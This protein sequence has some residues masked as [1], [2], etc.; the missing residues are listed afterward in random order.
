MVLTGYRYTTTLLYA[1][2]HSKDR[3][4]RDL[5]EVLVEWSPCRSTYCRS[6]WS[7]DIVNKNGDRP[8][9]VLIRLIYRCEL[10]DITAL[11]VTSSVLL[12]TVRPR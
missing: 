10:V 1:I 2:I 12:Y 8:I 6:F 9:G 5:C 11:V 4:L 7:K 3:T